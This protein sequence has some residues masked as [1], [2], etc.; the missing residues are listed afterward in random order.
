MEKPETLSIENWN[1][2]CLHCGKGADPKSK[3][4]SKE[5]GYGVEGNGNP[6][7]VEWKYL[8]SMYSDAKEGAQR[9]RP[10]LEWRDYFDLITPKT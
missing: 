8:T 6:C 1:S 2:R 9:M 4:H 7:G 5:L 10:D 3:T